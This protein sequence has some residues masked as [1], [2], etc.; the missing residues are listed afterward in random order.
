M[1][2][3]V[4]AVMVV[5]GEDA[6]VIVAELGPLTWVHVPVPVVAVLPVMVV[7]PLV[8]QTVLSTPALAVVGTPFTITFIWSFVD[9]Q[10]A[11]VIVHWNT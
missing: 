9:A 4:R 10:G 11:L 5:V 3:E 1:P 8:V 6:V 7:V 2:T